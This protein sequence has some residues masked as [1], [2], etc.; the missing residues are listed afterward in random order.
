MWRLESIPKIAHFY[1]GNDQLSFLRYLSVYSF[2]KFNPD[3][4][5]NLYY[6]K[7]R[8]QGEKTWYTKEH[9]RKYTGVNYIDRLF[10]MDIAK[11]EV[12]FNSYGVDNEMPE[13]FK[14]D[15]LRWRL[16]ATVGGLWSDCD[17]IYFRPMERIY[18]NDVDHSRLD[19]T[20]CLH[21]EGAAVDYHSIG[22]LLSSPN[23]PFFR[24]IADQC[25]ET[26]NKG[27]YQ[28]IGSAILNRHFPNL[29]MIKANF[30]GLNLA[31]I[32]S[33]VVYPINYARVPDIFHTASPDCLTERSIGLHWFGG[34]SEAGMF[35][36]LIDEETQIG[37][38]NL[39]ARI[40][41]LVIGVDSG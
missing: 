13:T 34:H 15:L 8:Y 23:N 6:P 30:S 31:N 38:D 17:I 25:P 26:L 41:R 18:L 21:G 2:A 24:F 32:A 36:N 37:Y 7:I 12:D 40:I 35:E 28:S 3:W 16:L 39:I 19:T 22:F 20:V 9:S 4:I 27:V 33:D 10:E 5:I 1:W 11:I 14:A 29:D